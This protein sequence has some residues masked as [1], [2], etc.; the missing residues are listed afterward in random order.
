MIILCL[1]LILGT[2]ACNSGAAFPT[3]RKLTL[4]QPVAS[5]AEQPATPTSLIADITEPPSVV[6]R[7]PKETQKKPPPETFQ[8][9]PEP[10]EYDNE[11]AFYLINF[12]NPL[13]DGF[14]VNAEPVDGFYKLD[15]RCVEYGI[16]M[17]EDA[18]KAGHNVMVVDG[19]RTYE[20]QQNKF[21]A[22]KNTYINQGFSEREAFL[23]TSK[24]IAIPGTS[25][26]NAG[27]A[28]DVFCRDFFRAYGIC[29]TFEE[30]ELFKWLNDNSWKYGFILRYPKGKTEITGFIYE[31]WHFRFV[32]VMRATEIF[33]S[34]LTLEE[35]IGKYSEDG[36]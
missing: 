10:V 35:Y 13:P 9:I 8:V 22:L 7:V 16:R 26:H 17:I 25:E 24:E 12:D 19:Y 18:L 21:D 34:G 20:S 28:L 1:V 33:E 29:D 15:V 11:W 2:A 6:T 32:G 3:E 36:S 23:L 4:Q 31:P 14:A 5:P 27:L 30:T